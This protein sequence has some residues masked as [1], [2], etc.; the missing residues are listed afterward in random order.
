MY[1]CSYDGLFCG[2]EEAIHLG[3]LREVIGRQS[4]PLVNLKFCL[5]LLL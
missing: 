2:E 5:L 1:N 3:Y 4:I